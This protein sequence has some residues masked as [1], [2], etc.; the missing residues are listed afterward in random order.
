MTLYTCMTISGSVPVIL[1]FLLWAVQRQNYNFRLGRRLLLTGMFF[2]LVPF[3]V[4]KFKLPEQAVSAVSIPVDVSVEQN[5]YNVVS[6]KNI[7]SPTESIWIPVWLTVLLMVW[8]WCIVL[9][10][11]YQVIKYRIGIRRLLVGAEK[12]A[13]EIDGK[14]AE[15]M[16]NKKIR[17]PYTVGFVKPV[18]V[19]PEK[20][21]EHPC[22]SMIY[23]HEEQHRKNYDSLMKLVCIGII[24]IHWINPITFLLLFLYNVTA[25]YI[26]DS[27]AGE[28]CTEEEKKEYLKL[29]VELSTVDEP[30]TMVWRNN[31]SGPKNLMKRRINYMMKKKSGIL[32][33]GIAVAASVLTVLV[34][35]STIMAYEPLLSAEAGDTGELTDIEFG[36]FTG[37]DNAID[38]DFSISDSI[39]IYEDGTQEAITDEA[40]PFAW[41][42]HTM[43]SG[44]YS[45]HKS[46]GSG[47]CTVKVYYAQKCTKCGYLDLGDLYNTITYAVCIHK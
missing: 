19:V 35:A 14:T 29:L 23:R 25:E 27:Y 34:S 7:L 21:L 6:M 16:L 28:D 5:F 37:G 20:S 32:R 9:F 43:T 12:A 36:A 4:V 45:T 44:Y 40:S 42:N 30:L 46:N 13:V 18:I 15:L 1:C 10:A 31:L 11:V 8:L 47:G 38:Y 26:C 17:T 33:R 39:F 41:C 3:Q 24:C 2:Y 22:F